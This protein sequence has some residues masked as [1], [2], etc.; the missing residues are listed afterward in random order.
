MDHAT[1]RMNIVYRSADDQE[2]ELPLRIL[3]VG[4]YMGR[5][6]RPIEDRVP[7]GVDKD[8]LPKVLAALAPRLELIV[9]SAGAEGRAVRASLTFR[10]LE[11]FGPDSIAQQIPE[12]SQ[13][14]AVRDALS[15]L[16]DTGDVAAFRARLEQLIVDA[17]GRERLLSDLGLG[18]A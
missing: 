4:D 1:E 16:K 6:E 2:L 3:F 17:P 8:T 7:I 15:S 5:D 18:G 14:L 13:L 10:R 12:A 11:D 9:S